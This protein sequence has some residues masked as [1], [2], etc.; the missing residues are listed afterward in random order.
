MNS[1]I[2]EWHTARSV[3]FLQH[4]SW[5]NIFP[6]ILAVDKLG[7]LLGEEVL[8]AVFCNVASGL[9]CFLAIQLGGLNLL[10]EGLK[11]LANQ[12]LEVFEYLLFR[13]SHC[14]T[15][16]MGSWPDAEEN[17]ILLLVLWDF[18]EN[19][20]AGPPPEEAK[21]PVMM[22]LLNKEATIFLI[23]LEF[24]A[25]KPFQRGK[26]LVGKRDINCFVLL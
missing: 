8:C 19:G 20:I 3:D 7:T 24:L 17:F 21:Q 25:H 4:G 22:D 2:A 13:K 1:L 9:L 5:S 18:L 6:R 23:F 26:V 15:P 11:L 14:T 12:C 10:V 16:T